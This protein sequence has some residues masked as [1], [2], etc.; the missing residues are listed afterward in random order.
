MDKRCAG[1]LYVQH[2]LGDRADSAE[3]G[4]HLVWDKDPRSRM[5]AKL[6]K[7]ESREVFFLLLI[8]YSL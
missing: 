7:E 4:L 6:Q 2:G 1:A 8:L 5:E 3:E